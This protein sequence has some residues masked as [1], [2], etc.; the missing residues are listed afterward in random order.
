MYI[1]IFLKYTQAFLSDALTNITSDV[2]LE[3]KVLVSRHLDDKISLDL[4]L[5]VETKSLRT[6]MTFA[7]MIT[8]QSTLFCISS[9]LQLTCSFKMFVLIE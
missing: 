1:D 7:S 4:S 3:D 5:G 2:V 6:L 9:R 8:G